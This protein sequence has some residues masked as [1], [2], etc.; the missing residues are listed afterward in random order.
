MAN[1]G[2][3]LAAFGEGAA[4]SYSNT[5]REQTRF[6]Q[7]ERSNRSTD[8]RKMNM[9]RQ[10]NQWQGKQQEKQN[11]F[12]TGRDAVQAAQSEKELGM[13]GDEARATQAHGSQLTE[14][15]QIRA[16]GRARQAQS[17]AHT[18]EIEQFFAKRDLILDEMKKKGRSQAE[19]DMV[20]LKSWGIN[21]KEGSFD[22]QKGMT[23]AWKVAVKQTEIANEGRETPFTAEEAANHTKDMAQIAYT[24]MAGAFNRVSGKDVIPPAGDDELQAAGEGE[25]Q[26]GKPQTLTDKREEQTIAKNI[27]EA[28]APMSGEEK[29]SKIVSELGMLG[30][31]EE[32]ETALATMSLEK[33]NL[34]AKWA[35]NNGKADLL[36][37]AMQN[38]KYLKYDAS[39]LER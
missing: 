10:Q 19:M 28:E 32:K 8:M 34:V 33:A 38:K 35:M 27:A 1:W 15:R 26:G 36:P 39:P 9:Q 3:A 24:D 4:V 7:Q 5:L 2:R 30:S 37:K 13:R 12:T 16:E 14:G 6:E 31:D 23:E 20:I 22:K 21:T 29:V 17:D 25:G 18:M 11:E